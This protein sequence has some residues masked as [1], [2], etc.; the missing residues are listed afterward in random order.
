MPPS[1][2]WAPDLSRFTL[3]KR[4]GERAGAAVPRFEAD[5]KRDGPRRGNA[6]T[7]W[8]R[9]AS[10]VDANNAEKGVMPSGLQGAA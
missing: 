2:F 7:R 10:G 8:G 1:S 3:A 5:E 6:A 9:C 4:R